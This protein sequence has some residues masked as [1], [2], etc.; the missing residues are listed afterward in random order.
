MSKARTA[1]ELLIES[2][3]A[4]GAAA[5]AVSFSATLSRLATSNPPEL[6]QQVAR[7]LRDVEQQ[8]GA[9]DLHAS[10]ARQQAEAL[11]RELEHP[12]AVLARRLVLTCRAAR[13]AWRASR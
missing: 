6:E 11:L 9:L 10:L 4:L 7:A 2:G 12:G 1:A 3:R 8:R 13:A 5:Q